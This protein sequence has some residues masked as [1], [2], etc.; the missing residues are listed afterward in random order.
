MTPK[1]NECL[2]LLLASLAGA[3]ATE[4]LRNKRLRRPDRKAEDRLAIGAGGTL[5]LALFGGGRYAGAFASG[6]GQ[7][8][9]AEARKTLGPGEQRV[10]DPLADKVLSSLLPRAACAGDAGRAVLAVS[11]RQQSERARR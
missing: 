11:G 8:T 4:L 1:Q 6:A 10:F 7:A 3:A 2:K 5:L 9:W